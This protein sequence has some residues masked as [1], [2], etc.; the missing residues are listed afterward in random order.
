MIIPG[1]TAEA[2]VYRTTQSYRATTGSSPALTAS[3]ITPQLDCSSKCTLEYTACLA[4]CLFAGGACIPRCALAFGLCQD[5]CGGSGGGGG[6]GG[7][8]PGPNPRCGC[9]P[10]T[11]C[12]SGCV[13]E[14]GVGLICNGDCVSTRLI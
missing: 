13:K 12:Q 11:V 1:F 9:P 6:G 14:P 7:G 8:G 3:S 10:G 5:G 4:G 2:S